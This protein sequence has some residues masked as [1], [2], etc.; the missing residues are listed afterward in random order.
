MDNY[1]LRFLLIV[2]L[3]LVVQAVLA[4]LLWQLGR[5]MD[6]ARWQIVLAV[7]ASSVLAMQLGRYVLPEQLPICTDS[8]LHYL[9]CLGLLA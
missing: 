2:L 9:Q 8:L 4:G 6:A 5:R 1:S 3:V 7:L